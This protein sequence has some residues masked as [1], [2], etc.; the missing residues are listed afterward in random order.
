MSKF[1]QIE[2]FL[3]IVHENSFVAAAKK[4]GVS[5]A[6][7][8]R[9]ISRLEANLGA[10]LLERTTRRISLTE[11]GTQYYEHCKNALAELNEAE[12]L[13]TGSQA[14]PSGTI[15]ILSNQHFANEYLLPYLAEFMTLYPKL[16]P[17]IELAERFPDFNEENIDILFGVSLEGPPDLVR[18]RIATTRYILC[19]SPDYFKKHGTPKSPDELNQHRYITHMMRKPD[20]IIQFRHDKKICL[21]P[22]LYLNDCNAMLECAIR[23]IGIV[24]LHNYVVRETI[25]KGLL[26][27]V[28]R[29]FQEPEKP[30]Y[31]YYQHQR[32]LQPKIRHCID[33]FTQKQKMNR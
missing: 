21:R 10:Q 9:Q 33:F 5:T 2:S 4:L 17:N 16:I 14:E 32:Y 26:I 1:E 8:S 20:N 7:I 30:V 29:E 11:I 24:L 22:M 13:I 25:N 31:L 18:T 23:G 6:A 15:H 27:E 3:A 19:A 12:A 28:L